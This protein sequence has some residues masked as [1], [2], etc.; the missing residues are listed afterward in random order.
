MIRAIVLLLS[1]ASAAP[2]PEIIDRIL[3]V[4][5]GR[6]ITLS[7]TRAV[8]ALGLEPAPAIEDGGSGTLERLIDRQLM[9]T[10]VERYVPAEP[11][12]E[13]IEARVDEIRKRF[14]DALAFETTLHQAGLPLEDLR[15][16]LR[17]SLRIESYLRQRF[18]FGVEPTEQEIAAYHRDHADDFRRDGQVL[19]L[20]EV[21]ALVR[22]RVMSERR[23]RVIQEWLEGLRR[24]GRIVRLYLPATQPGGG[25]PGSPQP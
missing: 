14:P 15:R 22:Q 23:E 13:V 4:V 6:P 18:S 16:Y 12:P 24:R 8:V 7:D 2:A 5:E 9:L 1:L 3:A 21:R 20:D 19:A 10:E 17:D 25:D 11:R